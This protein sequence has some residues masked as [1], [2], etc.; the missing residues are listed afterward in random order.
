[1]DYIIVVC[2]CINNIFNTNCVFI[3]QVAQ[4]GGL[5]FDNPQTSNLSKVVASCQTI[6]QLL[7]HKSDG[8][9]QTDL[10]QVHKLFSWS[11]LI[12]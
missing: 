5:K 10:E 9:G 7:I 12:R 6:K 2:V 1:M 3:S 4:M 8:K 11:A